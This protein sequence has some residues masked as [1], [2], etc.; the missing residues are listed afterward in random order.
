MKELINNNATV[1]QPD[2]DGRTPL[3]A[4]GVAG[5]LKIVKL[6]MESGAKIFT[7]NNDKLRS[8]KYYSPLVAAALSQQMDVVNFFLDQLKQTAINSSQDFSISKDGDICL[9]IDNRLPESTD[10]GL[11]LD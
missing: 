1:N 7:E 8:S 2:H 4:A 10:I 11:A 9:N 6:L 3:W 5:H